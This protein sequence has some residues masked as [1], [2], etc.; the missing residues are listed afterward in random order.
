MV[1]GATLSE[2]LGRKNATTALLALLDAKRAVGANELTD[3]IEGF[4]GS[5]IH[6]ARHLETYRLVKVREKAGVAGR[7][8]YEI[9]LTPTGT[10]LAQ[11]IE[12]LL[13]LVR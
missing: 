1:R 4:A 9:A 10:K 12:G 3:L 11:G 8:A 6:V 5:G 13:D 7:S 2:A